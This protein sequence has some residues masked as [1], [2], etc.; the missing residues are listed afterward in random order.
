MRRLELV[1]GRNGVARDEARERPNVAED[2]H[3]V[4]LIDDGVHHLALEGP[5]HD[6]LILDG[7][8]GEAGPTLDEA[9]PDG[10]DGGDGDHETILSRTFAC[11]LSAGDS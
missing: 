9:V 4:D 5:K 11:K 2:A 7:E 8:D 3:L 1:V 10:V 6:R